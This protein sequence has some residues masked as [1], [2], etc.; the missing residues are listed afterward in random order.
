MSLI[1]N[2]LRGDR[3]KRVSTV[4]K[5]IVEEEI[6]R[7][8]A[9]AIEI[10]KNRFY[11][12][13]LPPSNSQQQ[14]AALL[15][16]QTH[17]P[18]RPA[19]KIHFFSTDEE[20][21]YENFYADFGPL[22][23]AM[24]FRYCVKVN[25]KL[26]SS[27]LA[28]KRI[29][30]VTGNDAKKR[31]NAAFLVAA[32]SVVCLK[33]T[34]E[35][36]YRQLLS[37]GGVNFLPFRDASMGA[38]T[39][40]LTLLDCLQGLNK[41]MV[42]SFM[43]FSTFDVEEYEHYER[44]ENGDLNWIIPRK[45]LA[46][47]GPHAKSRIEHG[48]PLH[49]PEVYFPFFR[50][51]NVTTVVRLNK[52]IYEAKRFVDGGFDHHDL[53][54]PDGSC[55][56]DAILD[57]FLDIAETASG[58][59]AIH[60]KAGLGRTGSLIAAYM[61]KHFRFTAP[62]AIAWIR[63]SRPGSVIG[64]QQNWLEEKQAWLWHQGDQHRLRLRIKN[65][66][67]ASPD[68]LDIINN[69]DN[70]NTTETGKNEAQRPRLNVNGL[71]GGETI[72]GGGSSGGGSSGGGGSGGGIL[73]GTTRERRTWAHPLEASSVINS[74]SVT[75]SSTH[76]PS[77]TGSPSVTHTGSTSAQAEAAAAAARVSQSGE[78]KTRSKLLADVDLLEISCDP[79]TGASQGDRLNQLKLSRKSAHAASTGPRS[80]ETR[81]KRTSTSTAATPS[82]S[83][84]T[85]KTYMDKGRSIVSASTHPSSATNHRSASPSSATN[86][87]SASP[88]S[89]IPSSVPR[90]VTSSST[91]SP[92]ARNMRLA[93]N[94][95]SYMIVVG[96]SFN[97]NKR[98]TRSMASASASP[99]TTSSMAAAATAASAAF[100]GASG[101]DGAVQGRSSRIVQENSQANKQSNSETYS[102]GQLASHNQID[103]NGISHQNNNNYNNNNNNC[104]SQ[105]QPK[106]SLAVSTST[107]VKYSSSAHSRTLKYSLR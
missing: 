93:P 72:G 16:H 56:P 39:F 73:K 64:P 55:P 65:C 107:R 46:F 62:E 52:K 70:N 11:F 57:R 80:P 96:N 13:F 101:I 20:F 25:K 22:N 12:A 97:D 104:N 92:S 90:P 9:N 29:F 47:S 78:R 30:H 44:V 50:R 19:S 7:N 14:Q 10:V 82:P 6:E 99:S 61:M 27:T 5:R 63:I 74:S 2:F 68:D 106:T 84:A 33:K 53:F 8:E 88:Y 75:Y 60:C 100:G 3:D 42:N 31:A 94:A 76:S 67:L 45:F 98:F 23:L 41:A 102:N 40:N 36:A 89:A 49:A 1:N 51:N 59:I 38:S 95:S 24:L 81:T 28:K 43:D 86:H 34:P 37:K 103:S 77:V 4:G 85:A 48:Y 83:G 54:F 71:V 87:R 105:T 69:N 66:A 15:Q 91:P 18:A 26:K 17:Q 32:F 79:I 58:A 35:V 21:V